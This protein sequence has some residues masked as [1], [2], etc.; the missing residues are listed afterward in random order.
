MVRAV[1]P[2]VSWALLCLLLVVATF[3]TMDWTYG[4]GDDA[5][6]YWAFNSLPGRGYRVATHFLFPHGPLAWLMYPL[7]EQAVETMVFLAVLKAVLFMGLWMALGRDAGWWRRLLALAAAGLLMAHSRLELMLLAAVLTYAWSGVRRE[8]R[9]PMQVVL[10]L[11]VLAFH[12]KAAVGIMSMALFLTALCCRAVRFG[13]WKQALLLLAEWALAMVLSSVCIY[14]TLEGFGTRWQGLLQLASDNSS[15]VALYPAVPWGAVAAAFGLLMAVLLL[16]GKGDGRY[17]AVLCAPLLF[18][19]WKHGMA[20][21]DFLHEEGFIHR[22]GAVLLLSVLFVPRRWWL[23]LPL[24]ALSVVLLSRLLGHVQRP[25]TAT[26]PGLGFARTA[27]F[28]TDLHGVQAACAERSR[29]S[30]AVDRLPERMRT[31][32]G[33]AGVDVYPWDLAIIPA[34]GLNWRPRPVIQSYAAYTPW[35]D[36]QDAK[37]FASPQAPDFLVWHL[38]DG[39]RNVNG[40]GL[41][42]LDGRLI[43]NDEPQT[44]LVLL[45]RYEHVLTEGRFVL[46]RKRDPLPVLAEAV[47]GVR[48]A[49]WGQWLPVPGP[50]PGLLR[51]KVHLP[52]GPARWLKSFLY[53]DEQFQVMMKDADGRVFQYRMVPKNAEEGLW[54]SPA[55]QDGGQGRPVHEMMFSASGTSLMADGLELTWDRVQWSGE[56]MPWARSGSDTLP[57]LAPFPMEHHAAWSVPG[58][59][60]M[61]GGSIQQREVYSPTFSMALDSL[62]PQ[63][64]KLS[65]SG[66]LKLPGYRYGRNV[67]LV[68]DLQKADAQPAWNAQAIDPMLLAPGT[69]AHV[70]YVLDLP[71][72]RRGWTAKAYVYNPDKEAVQLKE[73]VVT[74]L[75]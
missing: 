65:F 57:T 33:T 64:R 1:K 10:A 27:R 58:G 14:G 56:T 45:S 8:A 30:L 49:A 26:W 3:P 46:L 62:D 73:L 63:A 59:N 13:Q 48:K 42:G 34:N 51:A 68:W 2:A 43:L 53:K 11:V 9:W 39:D 22:V 21:A 31:M 50:G 7:P 36:A 24:A 16:A 6:L 47:P 28:L 19:M 17:F 60:H 54:I 71:E 44:M 66:W 4:P 23:R 41:G 12:I 52:T 5:S 55:P 35:L 15:A 20:R 61:E 37:H 38:T 67:S 29:E 70:Q 72:D 32:I 25:E 40:T 74:P 18:A 69:W 75:R